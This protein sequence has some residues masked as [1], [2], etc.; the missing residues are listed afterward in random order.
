MFEYLTAGES[1]GPEVTAIIKDVPS[2]LFLT[3][4]MINKELIRRQKGYGR[5]KRMEIEKDKVHIKSGVRHGLTLGSP[6]TLVIK[7]KDWKNWQEIMSPEPF[8]TK[9]Q[10]QKQRVNTPRPGHADLPGIIKYNTRDARNILERASARE[11]AARTAVGAISKQFL[12][13]FDN[14]IYSHVVQIGNVKTANY[15]DVDEKLDSYFKR[16]EESPLRCGDIK[17]EQKMKKLIDEWRE[18]GD[19]VGGVIELI[20]FGVPVGLGSHVHWDQKLDG[21]LSQA[22]ISIQGIKGVEFGVGFNS[23][24]MPGSKVHDE[25]YYKQENQGGRFYR[26]SNRAGGFEGGMTNGQPLIIRIV[27]K[28]I[29]TLMKPLHTVDI[30]NKEK[31]FASKERSDV[32]AVPAASIV[33]EGVLAVELAKA[34]TDKFGGDSMQ[35]IKN[36]YK[37]YQDYVL[38]Y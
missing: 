12:K 4:E 8:Q 3:E 35:E 36:N 37:N 17:K 14:Q 18:N 31:Q 5:G 19:S 7:N 25:I 11:T 22:L 34:F 6:I 15:E 9:E 16:V 29:P 27:M 24:Q 32:C 30:D 1:H 21:R 28:P 13:Q 33:G 20:V 23:A 2:G 26:S 38:N 10:A